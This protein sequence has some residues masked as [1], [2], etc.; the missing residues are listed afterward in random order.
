MTN[1]SLDELYFDWLRSK[2]LPPREAMYED[3][4]LLLHHTEFTWE[5]RN[6]ENRAADGIELRFDFLRETNYPRDQEW[7]A[8]PCS[9]LEMLIGFSKRAAFLTDM[10]V[11]EWFWRMIEN[12]GLSDYRQISNGQ[13]LEIQ[14]R[15]HTFVS[16]TYNRNGHGGLF[17]MHRPEEDQR[18]VE[19]WYQFNEYVQAE[20]LI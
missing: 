11:R 19:I 16:R 18:K 5:V 8:Y 6:D 14:G 17:P 7:V 20:N 10:S 2:V 9:V 1:D 3:L 13:E 12:L 15:L 4:L